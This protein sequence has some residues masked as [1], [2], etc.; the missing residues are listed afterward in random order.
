MISRML[1]TL[2]RR[3]ESAKAYQVT[4]NSIFFQKL[5][6]GNRKKLYQLEVLNYIPL[7]SNKQRLMLEI[8]T[9]NTGLTL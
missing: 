9:G 3:H 2:K 6:Q 5:N 1:Y 4:D 8:L 7:C